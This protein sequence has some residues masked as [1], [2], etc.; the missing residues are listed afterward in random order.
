MLLLS[1]K[2]YGAETWT[3]L[4]SDVQKIE[5]FHVSCQRR[6]LGNGMR[7]YNFISNAEVFDRH[8]REHSAQVQRRRLALIGHV[9]RFP[10]IVPANAT[11]RQCIDTRSG[12]QV[13]ARSIGLFGSDNV[14]VLETR[15]TPKWT[16]TP[17]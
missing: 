16:S 8:R 17:A 13:D 4:K 7:W 11:L 3:V 1:H 5:A 12:R 10:D 15:G 14:A 9:R 6:I 2:L